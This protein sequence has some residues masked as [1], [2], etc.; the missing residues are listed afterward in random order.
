LILNNT[1]YSRKVGR[2][3]DRESYFANVPLLK[4][5]ISVEKE[6]HDRKN[7]SHLAKVPLIRGPT[8]LDNMF[9]QNTL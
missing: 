2:L 1:V 9:L 4:Q 6:V 5:T 8:M 3:R 7:L